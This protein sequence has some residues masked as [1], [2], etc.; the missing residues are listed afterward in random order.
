MK[1]ILKNAIAR[2]ESAWMQK[3]ET[4][5]NI[6]A[7]HGYEYA[8]ELYREADAIRAKLDRLCRIAG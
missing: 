7:K 8:V 5:L 4:A 3:T 1:R 2:T 6:E